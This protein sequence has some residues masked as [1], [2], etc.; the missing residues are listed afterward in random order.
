M[1]SRYEIL[2]RNPDSTWVHLDWASD[3]DDAIGIARHWR[4]RGYTV[5]VLDHEDGGRVVWP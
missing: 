5:E 2:K 1:G 3:L 4:S